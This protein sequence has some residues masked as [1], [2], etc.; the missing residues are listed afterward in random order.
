[1]GNVPGLCPKGGGFGVECCSCGNVA[2]AVRQLRGVAIVIGAMRIP[3][4]LALPSQ[5]AAG[6][7]PV[8]DVASGQLYK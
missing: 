2:L 7:L 4:P 6:V 3:G 5:G 8:L 1:M